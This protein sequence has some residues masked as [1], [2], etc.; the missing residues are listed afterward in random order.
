ME[1]Y[2]L[3]NFTGGISEG[4][5]VGYAQNKEM[6]SY[7]MGMGLDFRTDPDKLTLLPRMI[8]DS[9]TTV[10]DLPKWFA[11]YQGFYFAYGDGGHIY[12]RNLSPA[13]TSERTVSDSTGQGLAIFNTLNTDALWYARDTNIGRAIT[14]TGTMVFDDDYIETIDGNVD[15]SFVPASAPN[16]YSTP[17]AISETATN[18]QTFVP[19]K[20]MLEGIEVLVAAKGT[21]NVILTLH[22]ESDN[23][24]G[25]GSA[26]IVTKTAASITDNVYNRF[27]FTNPLELNVGGNYHFHL[28]VPSGTATLVYAVTSSDL[29]TT[30]F[31]TITTILVSDADFH[32][33]IEFGNLLC[34]GNGRFLATL[35]DSEIYDPERL[36]FPKGTRVRSLEVIGSYLAIG[37]WRGTDISDYGTS[38][39]YFWDGVSPTFNDVIP[40]DGQILA[41][42]NSGNNL[43]YIFHGTTGNI[44]IYDG[45][46]T[47]KRNIKGVEDGSTLD[48]WPGL[49]TVWDKIIYFGV[50]GG[51]SEDVKRVLWGYG[52]KDNDYNNALTQDFPISTGNYDD[53]VKLG[54]AIGVSATKLFVGWRD[55]TS[56][57]PVYGI[58]IIDREHK[59]AS[60]YFETLRLDMGE[61]V[62]EKT[63]Q[64]IVLTC[65]PL[66]SGQSINVWAKN[67]RTM[68]D[69]EH[70][71]DL[72]YADGQNIIYKSLSFREKFFETQ[73]KV[74]LNSNEAG[75]SPTI[76][77]LCMFYDVTAAPQ[78]GN[79][80]GE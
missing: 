1:L 61:P 6:I 13:W 5:R 46:I 55:N 59:Q 67:N 22:D 74:I 18:R 65:E 12:R 16:T 80:K 15:Q 66:A 38:F 60:G 77:S 41:I 43:L 71:G 52:K 10:V 45:G 50:S 40:L 39:L 8:L 28:T 56:G 73:V 20:M 30:P 75:E 34:T 53:N 35:D 76:L 78:L 49:P 2:K 27:T 21:G 42:K 57:T 7:N 31:K 17:A 63:S 24:V 51:T 48:I 9:T 44:T 19:S 62:L 47:Y 69:Y 14:L 26:G 4:S 11:E 36:T 25:G 72:N 33:M 64:S 58:D 29:E 23:V 37:T 68:K 54:A 32:P 3:Q 70:I 79:I